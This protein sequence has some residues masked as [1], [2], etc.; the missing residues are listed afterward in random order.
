MTPVSSAITRSIV[1]NSNLALIADVIYNGGPF[2][3]TGTIPPKAEKTTTYAVNWSISNTFNNTSGVTVSAVLPSY[4]KFV[5][6]ISPQNE[7]VTY[8]DVSGEVVWSVGNIKTDTGYSSAPRKVSFQVSILPS[9]T[10]IGTVP[11]LVGDSTLKATDTFTNAALTAVANSL[12]T[13]IVSDPQYK[14]GEG[15]VIK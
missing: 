10:Q 3:N 11:T 8:D 6:N 2:K 7:S 4:V 13:D 12:S 14:Y 9:L 15:V 1:V 5:D